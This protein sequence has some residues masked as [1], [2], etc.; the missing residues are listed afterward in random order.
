MSPV[1]KSLPGGKPEKGSHMLETFKG[2]QPQTQDN[3]KTNNDA[4]F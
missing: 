1:L 2:Q 3:T 4:K